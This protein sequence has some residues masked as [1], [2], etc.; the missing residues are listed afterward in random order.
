MKYKLPRM[1]VARK[2]IE[3]VTVGRRWKYA[4]LE[5]LNILASRMGESGVKYGSLN[6]LFSA[7][8]AINGA[9]VHQNVSVSGKHQ[10][11]ISP[12]L[13]KLSKR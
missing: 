11:E 13:N 3:A 1:S 8:P 10:N 12:N 9:I 2:F 7:L 4:Y 6:N 5:A